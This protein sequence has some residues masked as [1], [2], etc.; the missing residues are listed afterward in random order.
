MMTGWKFWKFSGAG[1]DFIAIDNMDGGFAEEDRKELIER[2]CRRGMSVG[3][4]GVIVLEPSSRADFR[5][6]YY[7]ADGTEADTCG[8]GARCIARFAYLQ[9]V[10]S[11]T[12]EFETVAGIYRAEVND[13]GSVVVDMTVPQNLKTDLQISVDGFFGKVDSINTGVPHV[14]IRID[15]LEQVDVLKIGRAIRYHELFQPEGTNVNFIRMIDGNTIAIRTYERGVED[16]TLACGTGAIA[17]AVL[18]GL[19]QGAVP[20]V[21]IRTQSGE[22]LTVHYD[23]SEGDR[24]E[25]VRLEGEARLVY[26]GEIG[27]I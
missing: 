23:F 25:N 3:A 24:V 1:N 5:M 27:E 21:S 18:C 7:N 2:L 14:V 8:N 10:V 11:S 22:V 20:P 9:Q 6:R 26:T 19:K 17:A 13:D 15:D 4:D 16:E 12:M